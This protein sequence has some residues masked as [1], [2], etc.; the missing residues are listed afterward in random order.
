VKKQTL[1]ASSALPSVPEAP[2][3]TTRARGDGPSLR[4]TTGVVRVAPAANLTQQEANDSAQVYFRSMARVPLLTAEGEVAI[5]R[6][7]EEAEL[8]IVDA[9]LGS[10]VAADELAVVGQELL[11]G[12]LRMRDVVRNAEEEEDAEESSA[13]VQQVAELLEEARRFANKIEP[14]PKKRSKV[15]TPRERRTSRKAARSTLLASL[16]MLRVQPKIFDRVD[17]KLRA[18]FAASDANRPAIAKT[19]ATIASARRTADHAKGQLV[20]ANLRLVVSFAN[21]LKNHGLHVLDLIQEGNIGLMRAVDKFDYKRGYKFSTYASWWVKQSISRAISDQARTIRV[22][23]HMLESLQKLTRSSR[24]FVHEYGRDPTP[25]E[26]ATLTGLPLD[27]VHTLQRMTREPVS[28]HAPIGNED[29]ASIGDFIPDKRAIPADDAYAD[30]RCGEQA[31]ELLNTL[32]EREAK[33]IRLRFGIDE[34]RDH[35][36]EEVG[37]RLSL[38]RERIRQIEKVALRKLKIP[39]HHRRLKTYLDG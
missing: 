24:S 29:N 22:P 3:S 34:D 7:I 39:S 31:R 25:E 4:R 23:V 13:Q 8:Q 33:I 5:A 2:R 12:T 20:E 16:Q 6:K 21:R 27:K 36:L 38:T 26:I 18:A 37:E 11:A 9:L 17:R 1:R 14:A 35:T 10:P 30:A 19:L 15:M 32:S 28:L